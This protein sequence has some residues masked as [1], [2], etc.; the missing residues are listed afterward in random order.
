MQCFKFYYVKKATKAQ[1][2]GGRSEK[3]QWERNR[4]K[5]NQEKNRNDRGSGTKLIAFL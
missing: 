5:W 1:E 2:K 3:E 4:D